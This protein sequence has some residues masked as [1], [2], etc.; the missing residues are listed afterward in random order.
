[1]SDDVSTS[2]EDILAWCSDYVAGLLAMPLEKVDPDADFDRLGIDSSVAVSLLMEVE[3]RYGV[4]IPPEALFENPNL[5]AV[6][7]YL[8]T[9]RDQNAA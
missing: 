3:D 8:H 1:V 5:R 6:A 7:E 9:Q 4:D 2:T